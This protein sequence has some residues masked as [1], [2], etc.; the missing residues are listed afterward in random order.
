MRWQTKH[1]FV[2]HFIKWAFVI[3]A[4]VIICVAGIVPSTAQSKL[5]VAF[6]GDSMSDGYWEGLAELLDHSSCLKEHLELGRFSKNSSGLMR[7]NYFDWPTAIRRIG[8]RFKPHLFV[9]SIGPNDMGRDDSYKDRVAAVLQSVADS[10]AGLLWI[11]LPAMRSSQRDRDA[12]EKN[13]LFEEV[14]TAFSNVNIRYVEPWRINLLGPDV[15]A[16]Y[17]PGDK[18]R[19]VQLRTADGVHFTAA[20]ELLTAT[21]LL[22]KILLTLSESGTVLCGSQSQ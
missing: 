11:G 8:Q 5:R 4:S 7:P 2:D 20:G 12:R 14:I 15:F 1:I 21:Y 16:S 18:G 13:H 22:P 3:G 17:G 9:M 10:Q 19:L 6:I